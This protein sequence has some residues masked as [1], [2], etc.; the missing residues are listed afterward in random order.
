M[1][2]PRQV[3]DTN[4]SI[5]AA[6]QPK[7]KPARVLAVV[8]AEG[9]LVYSD[10][11]WEEIASRLMR[12]KF[13]RLLSRESRLEF[14]AALREDADWVDITGAPQGCRD[15]DDDK[16]L[17]T[18]IVGHADCIITGDNDLLAM[19]PIGASGFAA[20]LEGVAIRGVAVLRPAEFLEFD[21]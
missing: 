8:L 10:A 4:V 11:T 18:A 6:L 7:G 13:D 20:P 2:L 19:R 3:H 14:L 15:P 1:R 5:S 12:A 21:V 16:V 9:M 17:E